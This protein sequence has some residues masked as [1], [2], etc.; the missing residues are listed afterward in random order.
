M[1]QRSSALLKACTSARHKEGLDAQRPGDCS[2]STYGFSQDFSRR[3]TQIQYT[4]RGDE[5]SAWPTLP[6]ADTS[7]LALSRVH[8]G[9]CRQGADGFKTAG[10]C[11]P[12]WE[13]EL[14]ASPQKAVP[15]LPAPPSS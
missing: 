2:S 12:H 1:P 5:E 15:E 6:P 14:V 13:L 11:L 8:A 7:H 9:I 3:E 4:E 10:P